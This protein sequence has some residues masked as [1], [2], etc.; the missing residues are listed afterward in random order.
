MFNPFLTFEQLLR[1]H[2]G[3]L[4]D[5]ETIKMLVDKVQNLGLGQVIWP[6]DDSSVVEFDSDAWK[7]ITDPTKIIVGFHK[8]LG[9]LDQHLF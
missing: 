6:L 8:L 3:L 1:R 9:E 5:F 2:Q 7:S 4:V